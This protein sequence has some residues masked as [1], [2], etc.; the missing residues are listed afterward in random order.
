[1]TTSPL[2]RLAPHVPAT[3]RP[4]HRRLRAFD[5]RWPQLAIL[6]GLLAYGIAALD[7]D[8]DL[9][10][11]G[12]TFAAALGIEAAFWAK[13]EP[14]LHRRLP[15]AL[16]SSLSTLLLF[17]SEAAWASAAVVAWALTSK[18]I[19]R[20]GG[21]HFV[22]P[23]NGAILLGTLLLPGWIPSG[24]WGHD[25]LFPFVFVST[26]LLVLT[27]AA[28]LDTALAFLGGFA[29]SL[30]L[31]NLAFGYPWP[32]LPHAMSSGT[33][34][35]FALFMITDPKTTPKRRRTRV[36][37]GLFVAGLAVA[38]Q[39]AFYVRDSFLWALLVG[40]PLVPI[41]DHWWPSRPKGD[42]R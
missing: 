32:T 19:L 17:R 27:P 26:G 2:D 18:R 15:S 35:L 21:R 7:F 6:S 34:W 8:V 10:T 12:A 1:V 9:A 39:Q 31:R 25:I 22:N 38:L 3:Q 14:N 23:T 28:R 30:A 4:P 13:G 42:E 37:H 11:V 20:I 24:Q 41:L 5:P 33:L 29:G 40:A 16:I 36:V